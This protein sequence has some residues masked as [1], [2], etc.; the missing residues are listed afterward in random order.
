MLFRW[1][2]AREIPTL[3]PILVHK[4]FKGT[5]NPPSTGWSRSLLA[6]TKSER[7]AAATAATAEP[8]AAREDTKVWPR[9]RSQLVTTVD[10]GEA[11]EEVFN[12]LQ[13]LNK[14]PMFQHTRISADLQKNP[15]TVN[16]RRVVDTRTCWTGGAATAFLRFGGSLHT[17]F[18]VRR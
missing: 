3:S 11:A 17:Y 16:L 7:V 13:P 8:S 18:S 1:R 14:N 4:V 6:R 5:R 2:C 10:G 12:L 15:S 9:Y